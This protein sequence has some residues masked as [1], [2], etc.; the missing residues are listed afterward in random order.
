M[1]EFDT[2]MSSAGYILI[3]YVDDF[4]ILCKSEKET[5]DAIVAVKDEL[6]KIGLTIHDPDIKNSKT[7]ILK[8]EDVTFLGVRLKDRKFYPGEDAYNRFIEKLSLA[9]KFRVLSKNLQYI[10]SLSQS[11]GATYSFCSNDIDEYKRLNRALFEAVERTLYK[12]R[13]RAIYPN[14][15]RQLRRLGLRKFDDSVAFFNQRKA[16]KLKNVET[17]AS[18]TK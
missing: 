15:S 18:R 17:N 13:V 14:T 1:N 4:L 10:Q 3:R 2:N 12:S 11:W 8:T 5:S 16:D 7:Q 9:P 6:K